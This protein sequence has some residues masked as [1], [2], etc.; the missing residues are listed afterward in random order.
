MGQSLNS[1][2]VAYLPPFL[3]SRVVGRPNLQKI[4]NNAGWLFFDKIW[5][6]GVGLIVGVWVARYLGPDQFG[7]WNYTQA[8]TAL[9]GAFA[10]LGLDS[11][12]VR[13]LVKY[14]ERQNSI[15]GS[16]FR[17]KLV[18]GILAMLCTLLAISVVRTNDQLVRILVALSAAG[19]IFQSL[20]VIDYYFQAKVKSRYTVYATNGAFSLITLAKIVLVLK[21]AP[22]VAFAWVGLAEIVLTTFFLCLAFR[23]TNQDMKTWRYDTSIAKGL[24]KDSWPLIF[25]GLAVAIFMKI[26][27]IMLEELLDSH[28]VGI[29][30]AATRISEVW[31]F[32]GTIFV[33]SASP[34]IYSSKTI[35]EEKYLANLQRIFDL[36]LILSIAIILPLS[37]CAAPLVNLLYGAAYAEASKVL[38]VHIWATLFV[39]TGIAQGVFWIAENLQKF[40]LLLTF[41]AA[42]INI[43]MNFVLIPRLGVIGAAIA[44]LISYGVP[45]I[46]MPYLLKQTRPVFFAFFRALNIFR[47]TRIW[48]A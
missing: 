30:S 9:F 17:L 19:F 18:G 43:I 26:D 6:L 28:A 40:A 4:L 32:L 47:Y 21:G 11:I 35:S 25:S 1:R 10:T 34:A 29:Y 22:L 3:R 8:F 42:A 38:M 36:M 41:S 37:L 13:E 46:L 39:F 44:T 45:T 20:N 12:V 16:A 24:L 33:S 5:R 23:L 15:M 7:L 48:H 27:Q 14:P 2:W 31:Y